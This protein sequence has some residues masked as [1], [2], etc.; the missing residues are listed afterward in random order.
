MSE[1]WSGEEEG[2]CERDEN[3]KFANPAAEAA[4]QL[5][6]SQTFFAQTVPPC[7]RLSTPYTSFLLPNT[8]FSAIF[9]MYSPPS[10]RPLSASSS[11]NPF[12]PPPFCF[13]T[14]PSLP[15]FQRILLRLNVL[16][17][18]PTCLLL[19]LVTV[20]E[21]FEILRKTNMNNNMEFNILLVAVVDDVGERKGSK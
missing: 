20:L 5:T 21:M 13:R 6:F 11:S 14:P 17:L 19:Q 12:S 18:P 1:R 2:N 3:G 8:S 10:F 4:S 16:S 15:S 9:S 7:S